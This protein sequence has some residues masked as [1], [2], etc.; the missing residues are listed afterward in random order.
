MEGSIRWILQ[1]K[2][3]GA[4]LQLHPES[5][6]RMTIQLRVEGQEVH[7]RL[8]ASEPATLAVLQDHKAFLESSLREQGLTL[9]SFD[10]QSGT[11]GHD[12][13]TFQQEPAALGV[14]L[15]LPAPGILQEMPTSSL[16]GSAEA[17]Q[18][19]IFA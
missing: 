16:L 17:H 12:A 4:E 3:Q 1:T 19:E 6:G 10:L 15:P 8:W 18:I 2:S 11:G 7:A 13:K 9:G 5:L 14:P